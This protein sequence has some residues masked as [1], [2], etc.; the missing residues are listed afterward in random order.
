MFKCHLY[1]QQ[2]HRKQVPAESAKPLA[3]SRKYRTLSARLLLITMEK[4][5]L[6][7]FRCCLG[8]HVLNFI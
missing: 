3:L 6:K 4:V 7:L 8:K 5:D 2:L 1:S